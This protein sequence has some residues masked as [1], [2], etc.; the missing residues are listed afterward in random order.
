MNFYS[1]KAKLQV[2]M[3][4]AGAAQ[5][6]G[7]T[8]GRLLY[9]DVELIL[10]WLAREGFAR[11]FPARNATWASLVLHADEWSAEEERKSRAA[12]MQAEEKRKGRAEAM[13]AEWSVDVPAWSEE[14]VMFSALRNRNALGAE[15]AQMRHCAA[16]YAWRC[17]SGSSIIYRVE[18]NLPDGKIVRA[19]VEFAWL[20]WSGTWQVAQISG[21]KNSEVDQ[22]VWAMAAKLAQKPASSR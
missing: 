3:A 17:A 11:G 1:E 10:R 2:V 9:S 7:S 13:Q 14:A 12:A 20:E 4:L 8:S 18:G 15:G 16:Q 19:T 5:K 22:R 21:K 6:S